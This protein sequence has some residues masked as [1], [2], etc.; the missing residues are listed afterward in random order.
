MKHDALRDTSAEIHAAIFN[1][2][3]SLSE[4]GASIGKML[5]PRA[6]GTS[7]SEWAGML[8]RLKPSKPSTLLPLPPMGY[9]VE[10][11]P[12]SPVV[13][14]TSLSTNSRPG[15]PFLNNSG[16]DPRPDIETRRLL[17]AILA[18]TNSHSIELLKAIN[19]QKECSLSGSQADDM[20]AAIK[21]QTTEMEKQRRVI[22]AFTVL[23]TL[24]LPLGFC[25]T[26]SS[27]FPVSMLTN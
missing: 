10:S 15:T 8:K 3:V 23:T 14:P 20:V 11:R 7:Y 2:T 22:S 19:S 9:G 25:A 17:E 26:V 12:P 1:Q 4:M 21:E 13:N 5:H 24:F 16:S 27:L 6:P 18:A